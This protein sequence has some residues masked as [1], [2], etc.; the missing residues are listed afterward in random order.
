[1][2]FNHSA[3]YSRRIFP[4]ISVI[5]VCYNSEKYIEH[6]ITSVVTQTYDN[7][8]YII[9]DGGSSD[10]TLD[11]IKKYDAY[12]DRW[13]S[14]PDDGIAHAMN[15]GI[16]LSTGDY[17][18]FLHSDDYLLNSE[19][20]EKSSHYLHP[21]YDIVFFDIILEDN[22]HKRFFTPRGFNWWMNFKT[23]IFHQSSLCSRKL[24]EKIGTFNTSLKIAMDY[25][26][27]LRAYKAEIKTK[28]VNMVLAVMRL[29]GVSSRRQWPDLKHRF[30]EERRIHFLHCSDLT[31][32]LI[33]QIYW[34]LY[35]PYRR[36]LS[37]FY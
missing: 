30:H 20:L 14:E 34:A 11:I 28:Y 5:T 10:G 3:K 23:G 36:F 7:V 21:P 9:I 16:D 1:M 6:T 26:F 15:K 8:E 24:F 27:F 22:G 35:L 31:M 13:I 2:N 19:V 18:L 17:I 25:E 4:K 33:Y 37:G 32:R 12:I 29:V